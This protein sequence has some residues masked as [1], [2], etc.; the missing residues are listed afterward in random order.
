MFYGFLLSVR[1][2]AL[3][4]SLNTDPLGTKI[5]RIKV[6]VKRV[7]QKV[8]KDGLKSF[9]AI[10]GEHDVGLYV[11]IGGFTRDAEEFARDQE[12]RQITLIDL[13]RLVDH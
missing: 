12:R 5:P 9:L 6:Q 7:G 11:A 8:D 4:S 3:I 1:T 2:A 10:V 13:E